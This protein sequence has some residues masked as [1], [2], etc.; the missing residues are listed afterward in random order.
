M[1]E[2]G[3][4]APISSPFTSSIKHV[5]IHGRPVPSLLLAGYSGLCPQPQAAKNRYADF[6]TPSGL[7]SGPGAELGVRGGAELEAS[8]SVQGCGCSWGS[9]SVQQAG[10]GAEGAGTP[11]SLGHGPEGWA[12]HRYHCLSV[13]G[14]VAAS[15]CPGAEE[16]AWGETLRKGLSS[17]R[18][19]SPGGSLAGWAGPGW[20]HRGF[21]CSGKPCWPPAPLQRW[22]LYCRMGWGHYCCCSYSCSF[23][24]GGCYLCP[25]ALVGAPDGASSLQVAWHGYQVRGL[26]LIAQRLGGWQRADCLEPS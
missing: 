26:H 17:P 21:H 13:A 1:I 3:S 18:S 24:P 16:A 11:Q 5:H 2:P 7:L 23:G 15:G 25:E 14:G 22:V 20:W 19:C 8:R 12:A 9:H 10:P 6:C 4:Q